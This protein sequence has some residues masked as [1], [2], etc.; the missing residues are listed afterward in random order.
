MG[1]IGGIVVSK[2]LN[3]GVLIPNNIAIVGDNKKPPINTG[4]CIGKNIDPAMLKEWNTIGNNNPIANNRPPITNFFVLLMFFIIFLLLN[5]YVC[6]LKSKLRTPNL[7]WYNV[8]CRKQIPPR[9]DE[10]LMQKIVSISCP[11]CNNNH[12]F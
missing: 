5:M 1:N 12:S 11:K 3:K 2:E 6:K 7:L 10:V 9:K 8:F 4:I